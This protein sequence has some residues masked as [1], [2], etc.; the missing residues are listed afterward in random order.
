M[1]RSTWYSITYPAATLRVWFR[2]HI[3]SDNT[4]PQDAV[5]PAHQKKKIR[6]TRN[7]PIQHTVENWGIYGAGTRRICHTGRDFSSAIH[8]VGRTLETNSFPS[9]YGLDPG[10]I[11]YHILRQIYH[12]SFW[13]TF[14]AMGTPAYTAWKVRRLWVAN[15]RGSDRGLSSHYHRTDGTEETNEGSQ[16]GYS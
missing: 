6:K 15:R 5:L 10:I 4:Q 13:Y 8:S 16:K 14:A 1:L 9:C 3:W 2:I 12:T 11:S 7:S